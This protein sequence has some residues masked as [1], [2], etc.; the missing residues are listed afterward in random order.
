[1]NLILLGPPGAGKGTQAKRLE[2]R[3]GMLQLATGDM[4]RAERASGSTLGRQVQAIMDSGQFVSDD[5]MTALIG[6]RIDRLAQGAGFV[7]DGFPRNVP[8]A[9]ALDAMLAARGM[10]LDYVIEVTVD[11]AALVDRIAGRFIC[12]QCGASYH[13]RY[14]PPR[15]AGICDLCGS[16]QLVHRADDRAET[17]RARL[18]AYRDQTA[19]VLPYYRAKGIL[20]AVDGMAEPDRVTQEIE[21][22][23]GFAAGGA[24][25]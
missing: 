9:E 20:R 13:E 8:Q 2:E 11:E 22:I 5:I 10:R 18:A 25:G 6:S 21:R 3:H 1:M 24:H 19:P 4:L 12:A 15:R 23:L 17:V 14:N 7:L 16:T